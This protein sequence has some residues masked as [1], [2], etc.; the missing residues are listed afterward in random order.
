VPAAPAP[1]PKSGFEGLWW[2]PVGAAVAALFM[3]KNK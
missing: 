1:A 2:L 3:M